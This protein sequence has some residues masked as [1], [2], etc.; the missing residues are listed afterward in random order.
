[1]VEV[2]VNGITIS[3]DTRATVSVRENEDTIRFT[4]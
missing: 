3:G 4:A 2:T 1:V